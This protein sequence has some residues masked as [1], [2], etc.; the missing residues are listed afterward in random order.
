MA[1]D[2]KNDK[3]MVFGGTS[4]DSLYFDDLWEF[5][6][7]N[8]QW[9]KITPVSTARPEARIAFSLFGDSE[10]SQFYLF[11]G[12][13]NL[14]YLNDMWVYDQE[15]MKWVEVTTKGVKAP[16][17]TRFAY[18]AFRDSS[19]RLKF[20]V[21]LGETMKGSNKDVYVYDVDTS[22][23]TKYRSNG[24][25]PQVLKDS[26]VVYFEG[27]L[28]VFGGYKLNSRSDSKLYRYDF[29][30]ETWTA[31]TT[32]NPPME[33]VLHGMVVYGDYLYC[34][35]GWSEI[36]QADIGETKRINLKTGSLQWETVEIDSKAEAKA[37][38]PRD[39]YGYSIQGS[40]IYFSCGWRED[41]VFNDV[42]KLDLSQSPLKYE[43]LSENYESPPS[44]LH[45]SMQAIGTKLYMFGGEGEAG[46]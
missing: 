33:R 4:E 35:P 41:D 13:S 9:T 15:T 1:I 36:N 46:L 12:E 44:R 38:F 25:T 28:Y 7:P 31:L 16:A 10:T 8:R 21:M 6:I 2:E 23:W 42:L 22:T 29:A 40:N 39:S 11:G 27:K 20:V 17:F 19:N 30:T 5:D 18:S 3:L 24:D 14:G 43:I 26:A 45:H 32:T 37:F 34:L